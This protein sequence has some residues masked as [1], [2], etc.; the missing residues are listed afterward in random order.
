METGRLAFTAVYLKSNS[1][2]IGFIEELPGV[3]SHGRTIEEARDTLLSISGKLDLRMGGPGFR[4]Y[5]YLE[6]NVATYVP[7]DEFGPETY[8]R[9]V[10]HQS[11]RAASVDLLTDFDSPDCSRAAPRRD[12]TTSPIQALTMLNHRFTLDMAD[13]F[14]DRLHRDRAGA[15]THCHLRAVLDAAR[16]EI[17]GVHQQGAAFGAFH[18]PVVIVH[19]GIVRAHMPPADQAQRAVRG[20]FTGRGAGSRRMRAAQ[21]RQIAQRLRCCAV[22]PAIGGFQPRGQRQ[23][24][25]PEVDAGRI[26][27][28]HVQ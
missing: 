3:N 23:F 27:L 1:G 13:A 8:R 15:R 16:R 20:T 12:A 9:S 25:R 17:V 6:D 19:P 26:F 7:L 24:Q 28:K 5:R 18:Q 11:A 2:Y 22:D 14:A 21:A 4:L 10:Y